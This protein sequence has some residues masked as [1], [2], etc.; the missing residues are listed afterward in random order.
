MFLNLYGENSHPAK[1]F[2]PNLLFFRRTVCPS[3][4]F[5]MFRKCAIVG[6]PGLAH[7]RHTYH[8]MCLYEGFPVI[9]VSFLKKFGNVY[10]GRPKCLRF[11]LCIH[12]LTRYPNTKVVQKAF[13]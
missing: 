12:H 10:L 13:G 4:K 5:C 1:P 6:K 3:Q 8:C 9:C 11:T 2:A 7:R